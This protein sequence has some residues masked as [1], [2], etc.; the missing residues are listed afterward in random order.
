MLVAG[1]ADLSADGAA[2]GSAIK[3]AFNKPA[4][5]TNLLFT[6]RAGQLLHGL[7]AAGAQAL[8]S[9]TLIG[10]EIA[11][12]LSSAGQGLR[13]LSSLPDA[14]RRSTKMHSAPW[15]LT[16][17]TVDADAAVRRGL[18]AAAKAIWPNDERKS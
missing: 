18:S 16:Y 9:G 4:L 1:A 10:A 6:A 5:A 12:A 3:A 2:F 13:L 17:T 7:T 15:S 8:I 14:C 11:G